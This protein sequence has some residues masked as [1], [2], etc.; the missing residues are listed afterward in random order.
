MRKRQEFSRKTKAEA[1]ARA[2]GKCED[3]GVKIRPANGPEYDHRIPDAIDG[4]NSLEN[5]VVLCFNCHSKKTDEEDKPQI[6][7]TK[8][9]RDKHTNALVK[10]QR[11]FR[12]WRK[13]DGTPVFKNDRG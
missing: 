9:V 1:F 4:G 3:C 5:C 6:A 8:R 7:R 10:S 12:G 11:G 13:F 2:K